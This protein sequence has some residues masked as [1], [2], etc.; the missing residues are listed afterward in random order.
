[1][2]VLLVAVLHFVSDADRPYEAVRT[3]I[4]AL[5]SGSYLVLT[6]S[7]PDDVSSDVTEAMKDVY[8]G[9][10]A[11]VAPRSFEEIARFFDGLELIEPGLVNVTLWR[12]D[13]PSGPSSHDP[14]R[15][16]IYGGMGREP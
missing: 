10:S 1:V 11:Q 13:L 3:I 16:L 4:E 14:R 9:A 5:P 2:P 12:P 15:S 6:Q 8:S 7:T